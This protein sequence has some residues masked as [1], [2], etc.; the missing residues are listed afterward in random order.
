MAENAQRREARRQGGGYSLDQNLYQAVKCMSAT[1]KIGDLIIAA[2]K[3]N[4]GFP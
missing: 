4:D 1:A 3:C 2:S